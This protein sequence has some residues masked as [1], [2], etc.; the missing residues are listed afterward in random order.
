MEQI[1]NTNKVLLLDGGLSNELNKRVSYNV[2][3]EKLWTA[4]ALYGSP[5]AVIGSHY[6]YLKGSQDITS[7]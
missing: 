2:H 1:L 7:C 5:T 3:K 4:K 6:A